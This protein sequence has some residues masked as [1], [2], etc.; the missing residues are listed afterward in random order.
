MAQHVKVPAT[1][2]DECE[3]DASEDL[4]GERRELTPE[5]HNLTSTCELCTYTQVQTHT[6]INVMK[7]LFKKRKEGS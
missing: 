1:K 5:G 7:I 4:P 2:S 3:R 6:Q